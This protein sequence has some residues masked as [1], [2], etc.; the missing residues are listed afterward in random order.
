MLVRPSAAF[1]G[2]SYPTSSYDHLTRGLEAPQGQHATVLETHPGQLVRAHLVSVTALF[3]MAGAV[4]APSAAR[5]PAAAPAPAA[6]RAAAV[7]RAICAHM[8]ELLSSI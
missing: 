6:L 3:G 5:P 8:R 1:M 4:A 2:L 7:A